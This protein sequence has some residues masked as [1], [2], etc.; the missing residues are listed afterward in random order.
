VTLPRSMYLRPS[1][2]GSNFMDESII[3]PAPLVE[4][5]QPCPDPFADLVYGEK[6]SNRP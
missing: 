3:L 6:M 2:T 5:D 1:P 4:H